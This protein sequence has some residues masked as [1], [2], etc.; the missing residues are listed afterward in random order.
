MALERLTPSEFIK[1]LKSGSALPLD[2]HCQLL[3]H[4]RR[5]E[6]V[7]AIRNTKHFTM[8]VAR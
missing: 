5:T 4:L 1:L 6:Q 2:N 3:R 8:V 7:V